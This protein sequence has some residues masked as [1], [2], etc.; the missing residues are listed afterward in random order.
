MKTL[1]KIVG[2]FFGVVILLVAGV[3]GVARLSDGPIAIAP[4]GPLKSG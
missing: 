4:G 2:G 1:L 3:F